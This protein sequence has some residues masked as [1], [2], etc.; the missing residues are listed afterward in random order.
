MSIVTFV[1]YGVMGFGSS[2]GG[3]GTLIGVGSSTTSL[4]DYPKTGSVTS[5]NYFVDPTAL[6]NGS[7]TEADP[8][9]N[10][11]SAITAAS[12][13]Q[14][15]LVKAGTLTPTSRYILSGTNVNIYNYG[16]D[17]PVLN[18]SSLGSGSAARV[19]TITGSNYHVKGFDI[20]LSEEF[21]IV[22]NGAS[23]KVE[24]C[25]LND[26]ARTNVY[27]FGSGA[28]MNVVQDCWSWDINRAATSASDDDNYASTANTGFVNTGNK[29]V[30]CVGAN[31]PDDGFDL[32]RGS[33]VEIIDC[34]AIGAG[35]YKN[36]TTAGDGNG[37][38]MGGQSGNNLVQ[39]SLAVGV[40]VQGFDANSENTIQFKK[41]TSV[42]AG[43]R[44][45]NTYSS[46]ASGIVNNISIGGGTEEH[47]GT[48]GT[49]NSWNS[50][51]AAGGNAAFP[52]SLA[53]IDFADPV[54]HDYSLDSLS[55]AIS[56]GSAGGNLG[57]STIALEL[58]LE[59][60]NAHAA[61]VFR[62]T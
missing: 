34:V 40:R 19:F 62:R 47:T 9:D 43:T 36:G 15:I 20:T 22:V 10:L 31:G 46:S 8:F 11:A 60:M 57:A 37:F 3:S 49:Y 50:S 51:S 5:G 48:L 29:F 13:G 56:A 12:S 17:R 26:N 42:N 33:N 21:P 45:F 2:S 58:Y 23:N 30:R 59:F 6:T 4:V 55:E 1:N 39:G 27:L 61:D 35:Y 52:L 24:D 7:G 41:G 25:R 16:T 44:G 54:N 18:C 14:T 28:D 53:E 32:F 38:K